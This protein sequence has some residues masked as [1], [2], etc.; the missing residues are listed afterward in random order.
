MRSAIPSGDPLQ[1]GTV[2]SV[3][4][5]GVVRLGSPLQAESIQTD[6]EYP[7]LVR[8]ALRLADDLDIH[9]EV[10][11]SSVRGNDPARFENDCGRDD[12]GIRETE[13]SPVAGAQLGGSPGDLSGGG[14]NRRRKGLEEVVDGIAARCALP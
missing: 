4:I 13:T 8:H 5:R 10:G 7:K 12:E 3:S 9:P 6:S 14:L 1:M 11:P 2:I